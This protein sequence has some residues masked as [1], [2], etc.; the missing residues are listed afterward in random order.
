MRDGAEHQ[1]GQPQ[2]QPQGQQGQ[3][4]DEQEGQAQGVNLHVAVATIES[5]MEDVLLETEQ[6]CEPRLQTIKLF[7]FVYSTALT[8]LSVLLRTL[9]MSLVFLFCELLTCLTLC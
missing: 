5:Q 1:H 9:L 6:R 7:T 4:E 8:A 3:V 2:D